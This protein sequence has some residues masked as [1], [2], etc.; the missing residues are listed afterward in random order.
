MTTISAHCGLVNVVLRVRSVTSEGV[1]VL[2][3]NSPKLLILH[4]SIYD[5][6]RSDKEE[7][8][9]SPGQFMANLKQIF[10]H[11]KLFMVNGC[12]LKAVDYSI[13]PV[14]DTDLFSLWS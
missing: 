9:I 13:I 12:I 14:N 6:I 2:V 10:S 3:E 1:T 7:R 4:L 5:E 11:R 8:S